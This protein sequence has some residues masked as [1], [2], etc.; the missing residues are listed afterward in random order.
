MSRGHLNKFRKCAEIAKNLHNFRMVSKILVA[1]NLCQK[2]NAFC[3]N[4]KLSGFR[5][6]GFY[7]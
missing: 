3:S 2:L 5:L 7:K 6:V 1:S 4:C